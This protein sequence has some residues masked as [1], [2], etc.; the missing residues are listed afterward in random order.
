M[1]KEK[2]AKKRRSKVRLFILFFLIAALAF[3]YFTM[4]NFR[5]WI[6]G[7]AMLLMGALGF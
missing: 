2:V 3:M 4:E 6:I 1:K 5:I 7:M